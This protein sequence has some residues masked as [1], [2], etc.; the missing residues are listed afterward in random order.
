MEFAA[1]ALGLYKAMICT[2]LGSLT[3]SCSWGLP[4]ESHRVKIRQRLFSPGLILAKHCGV[5]FFYLLRSGLFGN[6]YVAE[7]M[8][9]PDSQKR[10]LSVQYH[11]GCFPD[12]EIRIGKSCLVRHGFDHGNKKIF[13]SR[14]TRNSPY[15]FNHG[16]KRLF[17]DGNDLGCMINDI[18]MNLSRMFDCG[19]YEDNSDIVLA[20]ILFLLRMRQ[21]SPNWWGPSNEATENHG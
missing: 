2:Q 12:S 19:R 9:T 7:T 6:T 10:V 15:Y 14:M 13:N 18:R 3:G 17:F 16:T 4:G 21:S 5:K 20:T 8:N 1:L 11:P